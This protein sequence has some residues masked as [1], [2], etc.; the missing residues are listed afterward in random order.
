MAEQ[1]SYKPLDACDFFSDGRSV[2]P[3][4][5]G[6]VPRGYLRTDVELF[7]GRRTAKDGDQDLSTGLTPAELA[8]K[9]QPK[10]PQAAIDEKALYADFVDTFPFPITEQIVEHGYHRYMIY[11]VVCHDP[12]GTGHGMIV[13]RGYTQPP[14][15]HIERLR[16]APVGHFFAV[17]SEGYGS[18]PSYAA[19]IPVRD[20]WA[21]VAYVRALQASQHF[22]AVGVPVSAG[23]RH[24]VAGGQGLLTSRQPPATSRPLTA[25]AAEPLESRLQAVA[26]S[27]SSALAPAKAGTPTLAAQAAGPLESRLQ[28]VALSRSSALA[29]A[30]A[31]TPTLAAQAAEP[32]ES[33]LQAVALSRSSALAPAKAGT[34]TLA[35]QAAELREK[36][37]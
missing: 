15:Y 25:Q 8:P 5:P 22:P 36:S 27:R 21:I 10:E 14:P 18:M 23:D 26:L 6:T 20:R 9:V 32:L 2:R 29:P 3:L 1:P 24:K 13:Q 12:L 28:A 31:G 16:K 34:P 17:I 37:P 33:R 19:Q 4:V 11:C 35:A 30:K 7:T